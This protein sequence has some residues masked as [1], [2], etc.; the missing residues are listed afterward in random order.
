[1]KV[2]IRKRRKAILHRIT[3]LESERCTTCA[4]V[5]AKKEAT[6]CKCKAAVEIRKLGTELIKLTKRT[7]EDNG[8]AEYKKWVAIAKA[9]GITYTTFV[10]R[11]NR[12]MPIDLA[13]TEPVNVVKSRRVKA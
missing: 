5:Y 1:M 2:E 10:S 12:K 11:L 9:N 8:S 4:G 6:H 13:A 7:S 3:H